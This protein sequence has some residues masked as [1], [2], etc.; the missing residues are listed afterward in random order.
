MLFSYRIQFSTNE[1]AYTAVYQPVQIINLGQIYY[2]PLQNPK[3]ACS[4][5]VFGMDSDFT[6]TFYVAALH[7]TGLQLPNECLSH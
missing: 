5:S 7:E 3:C 1:V 2:W 4:V 6:S